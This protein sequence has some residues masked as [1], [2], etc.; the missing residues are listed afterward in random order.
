MIMQSSIF[1]NKKMWRSIRSNIEGYTSP[2]IPFTYAKN[3]C[4][5]TDD[6]IIKI[7][8][9]KEFNDTV[10][11]LMM[12]HGID[13]ENIRIRF[14]IDYDKLVDRVEKKANK[15]LSIYE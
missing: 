7:K 2:E 6:Q 1:R 10:A 8:N 9:R 4:I 15:L 11:E 13:N 5:H 12:K 3:I 14:K